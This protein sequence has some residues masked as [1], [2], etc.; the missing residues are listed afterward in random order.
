MDSKDDLISPNWNNL[1]DLDT[2]PSDVDG[3]LRC[4]FI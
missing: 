4:G 1:L 3:S 2:H